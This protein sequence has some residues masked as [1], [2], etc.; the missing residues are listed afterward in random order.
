MVKISNFGKSK[1]VGDHH[2]KNRVSA[3]VRSILTKL[4]M[5]THFD[6]LNATWWI[7]FRFLQIQDGDCRHFEKPFNQETD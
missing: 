2:V 5:V 1:M 4:G 7:T 3:T 6:P